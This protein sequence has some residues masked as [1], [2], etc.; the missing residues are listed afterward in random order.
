MSPEPIR[1]SDV[2]ELRRRTGAGMM[3]CKKALTEAEGDMDKAVEILRVEGLAKSA[4]LGAREA[5]EGLVQS[6]IHGTGKIG[7]LVE[8][9]SNTDFV[10]RSDEVQEFARDVAMHVAA[11]SPLYVSEEEVP[12]DVR[13]GE[14][15]IFAAQAE[16][17]GK[18][19]QVREKMAEGRLRKW[20]EDNV[21]LNQVHVNQDKYEGQT[22]EQIRAALS[23]KTGENVVVR[24]FTR[25]EV[26]A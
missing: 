3:D 25:F 18:P 11:L 5:T 8:I 13:E 6:Y 23:A 7:V 14:K 21:L 20:M 16:A 12:E 9:D 15:R 19:E 2:A 4:K 17:E 10:A 24:R 26:G 22:L 1:A